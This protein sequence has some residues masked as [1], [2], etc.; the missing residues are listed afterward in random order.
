MARQSWEAAND[1][2]ARLPNP[3]L[4]EQSRSPYFWLQLPVMA[5]V[6]LAVGVVKTGLAD[7]LAVVLY[8]FCLIAGNS[9]RRDARAAR[10]LRK[11]TEE[12]S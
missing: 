10:L 7:A 5:G 4:R 3:T 1:P 12:Q 2:A 6:L 8:F 9:A 11:P